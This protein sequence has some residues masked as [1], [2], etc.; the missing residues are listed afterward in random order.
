M[1]WRTIAYENTGAAACGWVAIVPTVIR[2]NGVETSLATSLIQTANK[3]RDFGSL[4]PGWHYGSGGPIPKPMRDVA[5]EVLISFAINGFHRTNAFAGENLEILVCAYHGD[6]YLAV[7]IEPD[8]TMSFRH[9]VNNIDHIYAEALNK[10]QVRDAIAAARG[11]IW[12]SLGSSIQTISTERRAASMTFPLNA[13][14]MEA[15][16]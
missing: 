4:T 3:I 1:A 2:I 14:R 8:L 12:S 9:E 10:Q 15:C 13:L 6:H 5:Q 11:E 16:L 7:I